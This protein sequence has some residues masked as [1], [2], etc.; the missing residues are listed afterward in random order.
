MTSNASD[1]PRQVLD[2]LKGFLAHH[3]F[4]KGFA[5]VSQ[6]LWQ[7][8]RFQLFSCEEVGTNKGT[9]E[10]L[11]FEDAPARQQIKLSPRNGHNVF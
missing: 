5:N 1:K 7:R 6:K 10:K 9:T 2:F 11:N 3:T 8:I 4:L